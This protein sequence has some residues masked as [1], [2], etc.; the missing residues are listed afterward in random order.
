MFFKYVF[1]FKKNYKNIITHKLNLIIKYLNKKKQQN[2]IKQFLL[3]L[4]QTKLECKKV[5][6]KLNLSYF[7]KKLRQKKQ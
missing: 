2:E 6:Q 5:F 4:S 7:S 1:I 3:N